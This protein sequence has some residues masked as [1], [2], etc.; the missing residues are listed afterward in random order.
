M[1]AN[2][3]KQIYSKLIKQ[4]YNPFANNIEETV[5]NDTMMLGLIKVTQDIV[6]IVNILNAFNYEPDILVGKSMMERENFSKKYPN[7][8]IKSINIFLSNE[9]THCK[10]YINNID[11]N[12]LQQLDHIY[13][14]VTFKDNNS[15]SIFSNPNQ[16]NKLMGIEKI[17]NSVEQNVDDG[18]EGSLKQITVKAL[19]ESPLR[20]KFTLFQFYNVIIF[21][22][23]FIFLLMATGSGFS[24]ES[25][26]GYGAFSY[27][28]IV[29]YHEFYRLFT[30]MFI[31]GSFGHLFANM[32]TLYVFGR[33]LEL[34]TSHVNF[35]ATYFLSGLSANVLML[36]FPSS[37]VMVGASGCIF[38]LIGA[39]L[40]LTFYFKRTIFGLSFSSIFAIALMNIFYSIIVPEVSLAVH[41]FGL[42]FGMIIGFV[43]ALDI[44]QK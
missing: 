2:Y 34:T 41:T 18:H 32:F 30:C 19:Y 29:N 9:D 6:Y 22:N 27:D 39:T 4:E 3:A 31:H 25:L 21:V 33:I 7:I 20:I 13:W 24:T 11:T 16:P 37:A 40:V 14:S 28:R 17:I 38:G 15:I 12:L 23:I 44:K 8:N 10:D 5:S 26:L 1:F 35:L 43:Y 42:I 36:L